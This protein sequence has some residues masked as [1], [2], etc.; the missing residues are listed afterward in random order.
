[1]AKRPSLSTMGQA[2]ATVPGER[3]KPGTAAPKADVVQPDSGQQEAPE[4]VEAAAKKKTMKSI[5]FEVEPSLWRELKLQ[6]V[7][8]ERG[9]NAI[10]RDAALRYLQEEGGN[11]KKDD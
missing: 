8:E 9:V 6:A 2:A 10:L 1:M 4:T 3:K 7:Y 11:R 5:H